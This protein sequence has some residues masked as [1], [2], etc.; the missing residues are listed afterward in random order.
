MNAERAAWWRGFARGY[1]IGCVIGLP[2]VLFAW[3]VLA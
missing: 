1:R 3:L 2:I